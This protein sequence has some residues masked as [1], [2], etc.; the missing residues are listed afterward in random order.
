MWYKLYIELGLQFKLVSSYHLHLLGM[1]GFKLGRSHSRIFLLPD[2]N[3]SATAGEVLV[4]RAI[5]VCVVA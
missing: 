4:T 2:H 5:T 1:Q 3:Y